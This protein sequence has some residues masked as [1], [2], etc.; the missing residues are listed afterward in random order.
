LRQA[1]RGRTKALYL[2]PA[3]FAVWANFH[4]AWIV[5]L[6]T[7]AVWLAGDAW[8]RRTLGHTGL[9][10]GIG[11]A[12]ALATL[13][14]PY[15]I[16][17]W[18]FV[19]ETVR[20][21]RPDITDWNP[22][23]QLPPA[24]LVVEALLPVAALVAIWAAANRDR[25]RISLRDAGVVLLL[26]VAT[27]RVGRVDAFFQAA[28]A[29]TFATP[30]VALFSKVEANARRSLLRPSLAVGVF[31]GALTLYVGWAA[32]ANL[33]VVHV[34]GY[35]IPDRAAAMALRQTRP[36]ARVLT[37]FNWGEYALWQLSPA[38]IRVS[39][40]GRRETVYS[41]RV[42]SD[43]LRFYS[44]DLG[45]IDYPDRIGADHVW[46]PSDVPMIEPLVRHGWTKVLDT[47]KSV[48]LARTGTPIDPQLGHVSGP[49]VFPWP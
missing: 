6:A 3:C 49:D 45:M 33:R 21:A 18:R 15:G 1:D 40:D 2:V 28:L 47:G 27:F 29:F 46:L 41:E 32:I 19:I 20:P 38:G 43:H 48:V 44:G 17:L 16:G 35:W 8:Q 11:I 4:G 42:T 12:S 9:L 22:F 13:I 25:W 36:G 31:A 10:A 39:M 23:L 5:G 7:L 14:N 34:E 37:W 30:L 24:V 26:A